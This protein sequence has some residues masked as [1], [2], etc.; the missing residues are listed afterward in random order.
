MYGRLSSPPSI[1]QEVGIEV[2]EVI[3]KATLTRTFRVIARSPLDATERANTM[4]S[5][6]NNAEVLNLEFGV[7][8]SKDRP[9]NN[10]K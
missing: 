10:I 6:E 9:D 7:F 2:Y 5:N 3:V 4:F 1:V 8:L